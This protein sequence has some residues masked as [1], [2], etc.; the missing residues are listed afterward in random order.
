[1][2]V[3]RLQSI[4]ALKQSQSKLL[5]QL[6]NMQFIEPCVQRALVVPGDDDFS[7]EFST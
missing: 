6:R 5:R 3:Q 7:Y 2:Q 1:M 4:V